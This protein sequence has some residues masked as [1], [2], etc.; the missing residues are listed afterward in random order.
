MRYQQR[1]TEPPVSTMLTRDERLRVD[2]AGFGLFTAHHRDNVDDVLRDLREQRSRAVIVSTAFCQYGEEITRVARLIREFPQV[3]AVALLSEMDRGTARA[4]LT[5][6]QCGIRTL[7]DV[8]EPAGWK[9]LRN[10]L[11]NEHSSEL[12]RKALGLVLHDLHSATSGGKRFFEV[13]F[14][15]A[16]RTGTIR[17]LATG[18]Q[19]LPSTLMSRFFRAGLPAPKRYLSY[20]RL[21]FASRMLENPGLS[22]GRVAVRLDYSSAQSFSRHVRTTIGMSATEFRARYDADGMVQLFRDH[23]VAP[24]VDCWSKF[25]P[26]VATRRRGRPQDQPARL[27]SPERG[28]AV[29]ADATV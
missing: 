28:T 16:P 19:V 2:A 9:E 24:F 15:V 7:V 14:A 29:A 20:A 12:R 10:L 6:G 18:L 26:M 4:V 5:L 23:L 8:R 22:I 21:I 3:P 25:D 13:L 1:I 11:L 27:T 17:E